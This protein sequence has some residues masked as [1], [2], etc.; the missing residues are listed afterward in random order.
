MAKTVFS[1]EPLPV[2]PAVGNAELE[3]FHRK[4]VDYLRRL[5]AKISQFVEGAGQGTVMCFAAYRTAAQTLASTYDG[6]EWTTE[7][8]KDPAYEHSTSVNPDRVTIKLPGFYVVLVDLEGT[9]QFEALVELRLGSET[10]DVI[11][12]KSYVSVAGCVSASVPLPLIADTVVVVKAR[13]IG[14]LEESGSRITIIRLAVDSAGWG[15]NPE[16]PWFTNTTGSTETPYVTITDYL[17][18]DDVVVD[19]SSTGLI[20]RSPDGHYW[21]VQVTNLGALTTT[22]LGTSL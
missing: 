11:F 15:N 20:L 5:G 6:V 22:D 14:D 13:G 1:G 9:D 2:P 3:A 16:P 10:G 18:D 17:F 19:D 7:L 21:R 4:L 8:R 12:S